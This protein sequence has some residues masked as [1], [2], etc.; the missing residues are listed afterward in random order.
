MAVESAR[1]LVADGDSGLRQ[2][3]YGALLNHDIDSDCVSSTSEA[4]AKLGAETYGVVVVDVALP[5][6]DVDRVIERIEGIP[7]SQRPV[8]LVLASN[9]EAARSLDVD[10]VQIVLRKPVNLPQLVD[11]VRS[12]IRSTRSRGLDLS[13][14]NGA[15]AR[16]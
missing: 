1:V 10:I 16:S 9:P 11:V 8:V 7:V 13:T 2:Q 14:A 15:Q 5:T 4:L 3:L 6:G 12:C